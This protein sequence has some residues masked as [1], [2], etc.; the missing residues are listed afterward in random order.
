M[1]IDV[2]RGFEVGSFHYKVDM[3]DKAREE[4]IGKDC[5][6]DHLGYIKVIRVANNLGQDQVR[7]TFIHECIE[8]VNQ[9]Y[10]NSKIKHDEISNMANGLAQIFKKLG[11]EF[12]NGGK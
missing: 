10:C 8:A 2:S 7:N 1:K 3:S 12:S 9:Q 5:Y 6:G 11:I 4:L